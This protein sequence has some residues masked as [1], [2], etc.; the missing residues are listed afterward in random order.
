LPEDQPGPKLARAPISVKSPAPISSAIPNLS[1]K[2]S[3]RNPGRTFA[4]GTLRYTIRELAV[5]FFWLLWGDF[6]FNFFESI[7]GRFIPLYLGELHASNSLIGI[8]TGSFAGLV[9]IL[10]LPN[11]SRWSDNYR[12][13]IGRRIPF[14]Y[15]VTPL[16]V[17]SLIAIGFAPEMA[18][19]V[20]SAI[21]SKLAPGI[22]LVSLI[23]VL[24]CIFIVSFHFFNMVLVNAYNWLLR[25][26]VPLELI[27]RFLSWFRF[28][29]TVS[30]CLFLWWVF[31]EILSHRG[32]VCASIGIFYL[33]SFFLMCRNVREG[34][35]PPPPP[36]GDRPGILK[37]FALYFRECLALPIYRN[38]FIAYVLFAVAGGC[39]GPF[40]ML[41]TQTTL[42]IGMNDMGRIF[43][44]TAAVSAAIYIPL[45]WLCDKVSPLRITLFAII[46]QAVANACAYFVVCGKTSLL[47]YSLLAAIPGVTAALAMQAATMRLFPDEE[48]AQFSSGLN[49]F[50][51]GALI[52]GNYLAGLFMDAVH[53]NYRMIYL[54]TTLFT[55]L[56]VLPMLLVIRDWKCLGGSDSYTPPPPRRN[57]PTKG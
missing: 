3:L 26:V 32:A 18:G 50:G 49:V 57:K 7:F 54:W 35:Y 19:W 45:G 48:F 17:G 44:A 46:A 1:H 29:G 9:N 39:A 52:F 24:L 53:S 12:S 47:V 30:S 10:F 27:A 14:I 6:A 41:F 34:E 56:A 22:S 37:S 43:A 2:V 28:V 36:A 38:F 33:V 11:I 4:A 20:H 23:L 42:G 40:T 15:A 21:L 5:L 13:P 25:E 55:A 31:P 8:M 16:T 51:C